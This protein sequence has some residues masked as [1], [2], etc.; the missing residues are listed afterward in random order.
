M[1]IRVAAAF[2]LAGLAWAG[3]LLA[4]DA[5]GKERTVTGEVLSTGDISLAVERG[6]SGNSTAFILDTTTKVPARLA[7]G[8]R[9]TVYCHRVGDREV[10]DRVVLGAV[11]AQPDS[12]TRL[13]ADART[14]HP[15]QAP[16]AATGHGIRPR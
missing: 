2:T 10:A 4:K 6:D 15:S 9:V 12:E 14:I 11:P 8:S 7:A 3:V 1:Q 16:G 13:A 5:G